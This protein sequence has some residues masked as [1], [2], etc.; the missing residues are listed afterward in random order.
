MSLKILA[1]RKWTH[2][3]L[4]LIP[5]QKKKTITFCGFSGKPLDFNQPLKSKDPTHPSRR[6]PFPAPSENE[7]SAVLALWALPGL[8]VQQPVEAH[9]AQ[10]EDGVAEVLSHLVWAVWVPKSSFQATPCFLPN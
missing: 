7:T 4:L 9:Q 10:A 6:G 8:L 3:W 2:P 1:T 5:L